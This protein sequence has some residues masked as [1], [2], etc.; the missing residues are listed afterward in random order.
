MDPLQERLVH[1]ALHIIGD[2]GFVL[3]GGHAIELHS[4]R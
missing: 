1:I 3:G 4:C 2:R